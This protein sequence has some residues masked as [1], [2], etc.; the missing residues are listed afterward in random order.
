MSKADKEFEIESLM[1]R[2]AQGELMAMLNISIAYGRMENWEESYFWGSL[3]ERYER[4][5]DRPTSDCFGGPHLTPEQKAAVDKRVA[6]WEPEQI[7]EEVKQG[8][9]D[10]QLRAQGGDAQAQFD[11]GTLLEFGHHYWS[12]WGLK[13]D[14]AESRKWW[15]KAAEQGHVDAQYA[16]GEA[17]SKGLGVKPNYIEAMKWYQLAADQGHADA[18][19]N[20]SL[21]NEHGYGASKK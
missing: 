1:P 8:L 3:A 10:L 12:G 7:S 5:K 21:L 2:A 14:Y 9:A 17:F 18:Q 11:L 16:L 20:I 19:K 4:K 15:T 6:E 13:S